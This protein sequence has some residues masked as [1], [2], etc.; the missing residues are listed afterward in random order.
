MPP[1]LTR[2]DH[3]VLTV[4]DPDKSVAFYCGV[5]GMTPAP[6]KVAD[7]TTRMAVRYG[8]QKINLHPARSP[9]QPHADAPTC[10]AA[11]LCFL[12]ETPLAEWQAHIAA[13]GVAIESGPVARSGAMGPILSIY[14]RDPDGNL[15]EISVQ[16]SS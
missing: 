13:C 12:T 9:Y 14:L 15:I 7:G 6:F 4:A 10:G 16:A 1:S 3:F 11:D 2:L 8:A 5:L